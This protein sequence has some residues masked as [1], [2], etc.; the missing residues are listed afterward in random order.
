MVR[1][2]RLDLRCSVLLGLCPR[3]MTLIRFYTT[4]NLLPI[5]KEGGGVIMIAS[6]GGGAFY[7]EFDPG[8]EK[9]QNR[10]KLNMI[11]QGRRDSLFLDAI[12]TVTPRLSDLLNPG[13]LEASSKN[14][15]QTFIPRVD[16]DFCAG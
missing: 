12:C 1:D 15:L 5:I 14:H 8:F 2:W 11:R 13:I 7:D 9:P 16:A 4:Y 10:Y 6:P 3:E